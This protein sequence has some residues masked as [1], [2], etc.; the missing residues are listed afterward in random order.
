MKVVWIERVVVTVKQICRDSVNAGLCCVA[1][2]RRIYLGIPALYS[3]TTGRDLGSGKSKQ[4]IEKA[5][6]GSW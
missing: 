2:V 1:R 6:H 3:L 4:W 5:C